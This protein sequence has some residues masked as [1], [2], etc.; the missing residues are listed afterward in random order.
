MQLLTDQPQQGRS[1]LR[2]IVVR[3]ETPADKDEVFEVNRL[4]FGS[5]TESRLVDRLRVAA[6]PYVSL[7][8]VVRGRIAGHIFFSP[9][10]VGRGSTDSLCMGLGPMAVLPRMQNKGIGTALINE[11]LARCRE[12]NA[13]AVYVLGHPD[14]Y[15]RFGFQSAS[16]RGFR[17]K[18]ERYD[19]FFFVLEL[20]DGFLSTCSGSV[21][22]HDAFDS[23]Q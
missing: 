7:V 10:T 21:S 11:G 17:Y 9:V 12:L 16:Q 23:P 3:P 15:T 2:E 19:A 18:S 20:E 1:R 14:Y 5:D 22:Y 8:A 13:A 4:A 6:S